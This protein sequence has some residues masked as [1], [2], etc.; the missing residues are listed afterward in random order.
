MSGPQVRDSIP[1]PTIL[2]AIREAKELN[3]YNVVFTGGEATLRWNDLLTAIRYAH[4]LGFPTRLV[5]NAY[6]ANSMEAAEQ[7]LT[8]LINAGLSEI[9]FSTGD[10]HTR[11][12]PLENVINATVA[13]V[14]LQ[15]RVWIMVELRAARQVTSASILRHSRISDLSEDERA[16]IEVAESPWMPLNPTILEDYPSGVT[17]DRLNLKSHIACHNILQTYTVQADGKVGA[18]CGIGMRTIPEL[19]V[20]TVDEPSFL[21][22]AI[23]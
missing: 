17:A 18:C 22:R 7:R 23:E 19:N 14:R 21:K 20:T 9:N 1:L 12:I 5:T 16:L 3:F 13:A 4:D 6:W 8:A 2:E 15:F 11:F 10:E